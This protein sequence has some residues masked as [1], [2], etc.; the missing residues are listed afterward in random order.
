MLS[1]QEFPGPGAI[2]PPDPGG[3]NDGGIEVAKIDAHSFHRSID[4]FPVRHATAVG[5][6]N[7]PETF[8]SPDVTV[9]VGLACKD[10]H[11]DGIVVSPKSSVAATDRTV[12]A[13]E[14]PRLGSDLDLYR[15]TVARTCEHG[16]ALFVEIRRNKRTEAA[17]REEL[18]PLSDH[19][20]PPPTTNVGTTVPTGRARSPAR[21]MLLLA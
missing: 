13:R 12:A 6:P 3:L 8:V 7:K 1:V 11:L 17:R 4:G 5:A 10:L 16:I 21:K 15:T 9:Q 19:Y 20:S 18:R 14:P 2:D